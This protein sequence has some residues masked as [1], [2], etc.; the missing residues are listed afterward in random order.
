[1]RTW[2]VN[3]KITCAPSAS[4]EFSS[5]TEK[6]RGKPNKRNVRLEEARKWTVVL[7][8]LIDGNLCS[9][10]KTSRDNYYS[11]SRRCVL[12]FSSFYLF[13]VSRT[14]GSDSFSLRTHTHHL[15]FDLSLPP[16]VFLVFARRADNHVSN[17]VYR[18]ASV[19]RLSIFCFPPPS[20]RPFYHYQICGY[21]NI[22]NNLLIL[23]AI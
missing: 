21:M 22:L 9:P 23:F 16:S 17:H 18:R 15:S 14:S 7:I 5:L 1:M 19:S 8:T 10:K 3:D 20:F 4:K 11:L 12:S 13:C 2:E 6:N